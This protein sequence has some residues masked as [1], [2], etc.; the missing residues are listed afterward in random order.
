MSKPMI[1]DPLIDSSGAYE[2]SVAICNVFPAND[3][4]TNLAFAAL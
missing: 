4:G 2:G 3:A 1:F